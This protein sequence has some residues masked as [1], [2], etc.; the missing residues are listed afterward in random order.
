[1][2]FPFFDPT[3]SGVYSPPMPTMTVQLPEGEGSIGTSNG[4]A[5]NVN[6]VCADA[7]CGIAMI[8]PNAARKA[9]SKVCCALAAGSRAA[10]SKCFIYRAP[11]RPCWPGRLVWLGAT[12]CGPAKLPQDCKGQSSAP[13]H[14]RR[15]PG[16][17]PD[18]CCPN[19][20]GPRSR[21][22]TLSAGA[23]RR[24]RSCLLFAKL[25][26]L[27]G[28][29]RTSRNAR[30]RPGSVTLRVLLPQQSQGRPA[31]APS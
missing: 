31:C 10:S 21:S 30:L 2:S 17:P 28:T 19:I 9:V 13:I 4:G 11:D 12:A 27:M 15:M 23:G 16:A 7:D 26:A 3:K 25:A 24:P 29:L 18:Q 1:M 5:G 8:A 6:A 14:S 20:A 22:Q